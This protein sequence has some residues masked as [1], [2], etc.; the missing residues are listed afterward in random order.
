MRRP[1]RADLLARLDV[2]PDH[3]VSEHA[4]IEEEFLFLLHVGEQELDEGN[5]R[6]TGSGSQPERRPSL[7][8]YGI[9]VSA[10]VEQQ[11]AGPVIRLDLP[12]CGHSPHK[13]RPEDVVAATKKFLR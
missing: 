1:V 13:D 4:G 8:I 5:G 6:C 12:E 9:D 10:G 3:V 11:T 7:P 2:D